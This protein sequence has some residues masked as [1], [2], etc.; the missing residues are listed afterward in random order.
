VSLCDEMVCVGVRGLH[1]EVYSCMDLEQLMSCGVCCVVNYCVWTHVDWG[2]WG[3]AV[4]AV[5]GTVKVLTACKAAGIKRVVITSSVASVSSG[6]PSGTKSFSA[7]DWS[8]VD[9]SEPVRLP[10]FPPLPPPASSPFLRVAVGRVPSLC[11]CLLACNH[12]L[13][14]HL[15]SRCVNPPR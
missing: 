8:D 9:K 1:F 14:C 6:A 15:P 2:S 5:D 4:Q 11:A 10:P 12:I 7:E 13:I 3:H